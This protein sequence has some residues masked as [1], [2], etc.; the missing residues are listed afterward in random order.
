MTASSGNQIG[1]VILAAG[2]SSRMGQIKQL[3]PW[4]DTTLVGNAIRV[5]IDS[6]IGPIGV[7]LGAGADEIF[8]KHGE[9]D[10]YF[11]H[12][13]L[14]PDGQGTSVVAGVKWAMAQNLDGVLFLL[15]DQPHITADILRMMMS[16]A[17]TGTDGLVA[18]HS[19]KYVG[20][21]V[22]FGSDYFQELLDLKGDEGAR[23]IFHRH[24]GAL[25]TVLIKEASWD[26][27][28]QIDYENALRIKHE[29]AL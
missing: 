11:I 25:K 23:S 20:V 18:S 16:H 28:T 19:G 2:T 1:L 17:G 21:P 26:I 13:E 6:A 15:A 8:R 14:Y 10:V 3:L 9:E 24:P 12:N 29:S 27:D 5:A 7:V 22:Y 4:K